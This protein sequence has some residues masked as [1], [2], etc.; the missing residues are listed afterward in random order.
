MIK[1]EKALNL[2]RDYDCRLVYHNMKKA[3]DKIIF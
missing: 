1:L 2:Y 3:M